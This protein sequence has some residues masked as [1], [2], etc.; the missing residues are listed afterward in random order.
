MK[1]NLHQVFQKSSIAEIK[2]SVSVRLQTAETYLT[3]HNLRHTLDVAEQA[4]RIALEEGISE[5]ERLLLQ[6]AALYHDIGYPDGPK[7]H[8]E[9]GCKIFQNEAAKWNFSEEEIDAVCGMILATK[10]PQ[11]PGNHLQQ[12]IC[13]AD[14]DY[15]GRNDFLAIGSGLKKEYLHFGFLKEEREWDTLQIRF[16]EQHRYFTQAQHFLREPAKRKNIEILKNRLTK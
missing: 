9:R 2:Q 4:E 7:S 3:Y 5:K 11:T 14:L 8:E 16:L 10:M 1:A 15:L 6:V 12:I 13:D